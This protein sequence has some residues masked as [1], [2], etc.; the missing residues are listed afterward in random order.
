MNELAKILVP[1][2]PLFVADLA[3]DVPV[4]WFGVQGF[5]DAFVK[6]NARKVSRSTKNNTGMFSLVYDLNNF[7]I[8]ISSQRSVVQKKSVFANMDFCRNL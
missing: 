2:A 1:S 4:G 8:T 3:V 5:V 6:V 7:F